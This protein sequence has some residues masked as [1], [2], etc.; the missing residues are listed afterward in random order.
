MGCQNPPAQPPLAS[1]QPFVFAAHQ[2]AWTILLVLLSVSKRLQV[3]RIKCH[4]PERGWKWKAT[5]QVSARF[6]Q[7]SVATGLK[8]MSGVPGH[9]GYAGEEYISRVG[10]GKPSWFPGG[11]GERASW[12]LC[13]ETDS[14]SNGLQE[15]NGGKGTE[16]SGF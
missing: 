2:Q 6:S 5:W 8:E 3:S 4:F 14:T 10:Q 15:G 7:S 13:T 9:A 12:G 11:A 16:F 1:Y